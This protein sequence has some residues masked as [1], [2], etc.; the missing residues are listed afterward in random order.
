MLGS[1]VICIFNELDWSSKEN[2]YSF[3][4]SKYLYFFKQGISKKRL[5]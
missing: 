3:N 2:K 4:S 1:K 5:N